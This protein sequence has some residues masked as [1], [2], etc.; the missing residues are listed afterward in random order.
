MCSNYQNFP[1]QIL[2][3]TWKL[4]E[5]QLLFPQHFP[6]SS[7]GKE[8]SCNAGDSGLIPGSG[9]STREGMGNPLQYSW[10]PPVVQLVKKIHLHCGKPGF[11]PW[12]GKIPWKRGRLPTPVLA[13]RISWTVWSMGSQRVRHDWTTFTFTT[14]PCFRLFL[15]YL[16]LKYLITLFP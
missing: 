15:K 6:E 5:M 3:I 4:F 2:A 9:R 11:D 8:S 1:L 13:W 12:V 14:L 7:A 16:S 10:P